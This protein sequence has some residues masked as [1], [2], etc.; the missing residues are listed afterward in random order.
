MKITEMAHLYVK[1]ALREGGVAV[2]ATAGNG[3]DTLFLARLA[4]PGGR[5]YAF[6]IQEEALQ[7]TSA[8]LQQENLLDR[9]KLIK[10]GHEQMSAYVNEAVSAVM[11]NLG[12]L[13]GGDHRI[14][15]GKGTTLAALKEA[16]TLLQNGGVIT[17]VAYPGHPGGKEEQE[18][19]MDYC[20]TLNSREYRVAYTFYLNQAHHPPV[21][22]TVH[23]L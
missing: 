10:A 11:F 14:V 12:Y 3:H 18:A 23:K 8:L 16:L 6:D 17:V 13:P 22:I 2:D 7:R 5:V 21:L 4:G 19:L 9:V 1:T 20:K 15:T